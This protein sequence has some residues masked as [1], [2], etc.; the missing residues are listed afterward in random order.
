[1]Q[2]IVDVKNIKRSPIN[3]YSFSKPY[4]EGTRERKL[5]IQFCPRAQQFQFFPRPVSIFSGRRDLEW[6]EV[7]GFG[8]LYSYTVAAMGPGPFRGHEP[9]VVGLIE[10]DVGVR[11][12]ANVVNIAIDQ[13]SIG[14]RLRP[15]WLP[16]GDGTHLLMFEPSKV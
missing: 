12:I 7:D 13:V 8:A 4:W 16:Q 10:L 1:M 14:M 2:T 3:P 5:M 6:R 11:I 15:F 9:Y